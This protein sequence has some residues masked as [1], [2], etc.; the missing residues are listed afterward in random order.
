MTPEWPFKPGELVHVRGEGVSW[1]ESLRGVTLTVVGVS[2][3]K[4]GEPYVR[5]S[6]GNETFGA[7]ATDLLPGAAA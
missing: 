5:I 1:G 2:V 6:D 7:V 3:E 4:F